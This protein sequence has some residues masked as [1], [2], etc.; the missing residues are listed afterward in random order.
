MNIKGNFTRGRRRFLCCKPF[1]VCTTD[2]YINDMLGPQYANEN[3]AEILK[4][5]IY[6]PN[7]FR[8]FLKEGD[9]FVLDRAFRDVKKKL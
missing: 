7:S 9:V 8:K 5:V 6:D 4:C 1:T 3:D 2:G